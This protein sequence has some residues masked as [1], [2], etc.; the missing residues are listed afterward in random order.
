M[1]DKLAEKILLH[2]KTD[3]LSQFLFSIIK[4]KAL[5][6]RPEESLKFLFD[7]E[8]KLYE[9]QGQ[10]SVRYGNGIHTKHKHIK[11]HD[12]FIN[13]ISPDSKVLDVG[14]G[15]GALT[16]DIAEKVLGV[17]VYGIDIVK[18][19]I[20]KAKESFSRANIQYVCGDALTDL[21][22]NEFN[23]IV[24]SNVLEHIEN[25]INFLSTLSNRYKPKKI[26]LRV[27]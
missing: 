5:S 11:Y 1:I 20:D 19:N 23:V 3:H 8:H 9:L 17:S 21:P 24:L 10:E 25:R 2:K 15:N 18:G 16:F 27:E 12:F 4:D 26:L 7:L 13:N 14:C 6:L 22:D